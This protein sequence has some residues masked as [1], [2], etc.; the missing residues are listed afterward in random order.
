MT[1]LG[2]IAFNLLKVVGAIHER[3]NEP[4]KKI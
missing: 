3:H 2:F 4:V 1:R